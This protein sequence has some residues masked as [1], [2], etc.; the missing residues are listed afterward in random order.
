L[1]R[2]SLWLAKKGLRN[3]WI[4][5]RDRRGLL[6]RRV[7][8]Y[9]GESGIVHIFGDSH[10]RSYA[11]MPEAV[12]HHIELATMHRAGRD[13]AFFLRK[14]RWRMG[15]FA[16]VAL[17][18]GEIDV[19]VHIGRVA[20]RTG[21]S[22]AC[23]VDE[24]ATRFLDAVARHRRRR[25]IIVIA[26]T[27]P[28]AGTDGMPPALP[29]YP[30]WRMAIDRVPVTRLLN[31]ALRN[32]CAARGFDFVECP[33]DYAGPDGILRPEMS[34]GNVHIGREHTG[35][36]IDALRKVLRSAVPDRHGNEE[37]VGSLER[38]RPADR[39]SGRIGARVAE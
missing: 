24:L 16:A 5:D 35:P 26:V 39:G 9:R 33:A 22:I 21:R 4:K 25:R 18:F 34:D 29:D 27:P 38:L 20:E 1:S 36:V 10:S 28:A 7:D 13:R 17:V 2:V 23:V 8:V 31:D 14:M 6:R 11:A 15:R 30:N 32:G 3:K 19:R 12:V 37:P